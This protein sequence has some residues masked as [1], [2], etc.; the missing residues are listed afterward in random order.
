M[1]VLGLAALVIAAACGHHSGGG[2]IDASYGHIEVDPPQ[3]TLTVAL[4]GSATQ[5]YTVY[6]TVDGVRQDI[7]S[8]CT[9]AIDPAFGQF[10]GAT[11]GVLPHGG[12]TAVTATCGG[13]AGSAELIVQLTGTVVTGTSTPPN[14]PGLFGAATP[15]SDPTR[16]PVLQYPLDGAVSPLN[17]PPIEIQWAAAGND[18]FH[19]TLSSSFQTIDVYT[20]DLQTIL[21]APSW[22]AIAQTAAGDKLH[23]AIEGLAQA[24]PAMKYAGA[25]V[26]ITMSHDTIDNSA[27][28]YWASSQGNLMTQTFGALNAPS[29]V[30]GACT[31]C[32]SVSRTA[33]RI[34]YSRCVANDCGQLYAGFMKF[35]TATQTWSEAVNADGKT[36]HGS[37]TTFAPVG[38]PFPDDSKSLAIVSMA[39]GTLALYDPDTGMPVASNIAVA[40]AAGHSSLMADWSPDG[41]HVVF[42]QTP[43]TGQWIDL[44]GGTIMTMSYQYMNGQHVFGTPQQLVA[45]PI[46]LAG[47]SYT[48]F[49]FPSFSPD[50][51]LVVLDAARSSW[52]N[53]TDE[54]TAGQRLMLADAG[55]A[56]TVDLTAL[57][58]GTGDLDTTWPHWAPT[59]SS[60][61]YWVVFSSERDYGHEVTAANTAS[62][63]VA[64]GVKQCKQIWI[65]AIAKSRLDGTSDPSA[66][67]MWLPGQSTGADNISPYWSVP[68][69][70]Q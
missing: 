55:G 7:T 34:G 22:F 66:P 67:P 52:R 31:A 45:N 37:Y 59:Q 36:I 57:D 10:T 50:G 1:R 54:R 20:S 8:A 4:G 40:N 35:D 56:W 48:N 15:G 24:S 69:G 28:Y 53:F 27:I 29:V 49:F 26:A 9:L 13:Q 25:P 63:C 43:S 65:G 2:G 47:G 21:D 46:A 44:A 42:T 18:L 61:Y 3:A 58:G 32:H 11:L 5:T 33:T 60:D 70:I 68:P 62:S 51:K 38:N 19:I 12:K 16:A 39:D 6:G 17:I 41:A 14:A 64:N 23:L 30:K